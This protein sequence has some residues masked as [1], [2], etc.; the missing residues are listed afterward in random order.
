[1][2]N[3]IELLKQRIGRYERRAERV[4]GGATPESLYYHRVDR[5]L[6]GNILEALERMRPRPT[7]KPL[8]GNGSHRIG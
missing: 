6:D 4:M 3:I 8:R 1:M 5:E 2:E 7:N